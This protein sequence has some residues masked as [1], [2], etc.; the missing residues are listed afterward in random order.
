MKKYALALWLCG[1][2]LFIGSCSGGCHVRPSRQIQPL[3]ITSAVLP[4]AVLNESFCGSSSG[5][6]VVAA[7]GVAPYIWSWRA[8][9]GSTLTP[10]L[11][12]STNPDGTGTISGIPTSPGPYGVIVTVTDSESPAAQ[13]SV[14]YIV[15]VAATRP[16]SV[17]PNQ[18]TRHPHRWRGTLAGAA[19]EAAQRGR[20]P[21][22]L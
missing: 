3:V 2:L 4:Q 22:H 15:T 19:S 14:T 8:A 16:D 18:S 7:G 5:F 21:R 12:L 17:L 1:S 11:K 13:T 9:D 6:S 10:G 20:S